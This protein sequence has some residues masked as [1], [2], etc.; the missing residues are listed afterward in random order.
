MNEIVRTNGEALERHQR[1]LGN[2][3]QI[4][5]SF[6]EMGED[7]YWI[8]ERKLYKNLDYETF[9][10]YIA[11]PEVDIKTRTVHQLKQVYRVLV[12]EQKVRPVALL[13]AGYSKASM[14]APYV[15]EEEPEMLIAQA[16]SLS[17]N[18][19]KRWLKQEF[20]PN[21]NKVPVE[22]SETEYYGD[23]WR[24]IHGDMIDVC[25]T[26][27]DASF[28]A[29]VTDPPYPGEFIS[30][31]SSLA[32]QASRLL[33]DG[34]VLLAMSGQNHLPEV[35]RRLTQFEA[36]GLFYRWTISYLLP[37]KEMRAWGRKIWNH[38]KPVIVL[39]KGSPQG[40]WAT[41]VVT[42]P[43]PDK[44]H[45]YWGQSLLGM[46]GLI[47]AFVMPSSRILDP[48]VGG[49]ATID[50]ARALGHECVG[51][52]VDAESIMN[53]RRRLND[54]QEKGQPQHGIRAMAERTIGD[55]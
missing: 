13:E 46:E 5:K 6:L 39:T 42:S 24:L 8:E 30:L 18:D 7:L 48:F 53:T 1:V 45:H 35:Y 4:Q 28:D 15:K 26:M 41:D 17:R 51:I 27:P 32:E 9:N 54:R 49:G 22:L 40:D 21:K 36:D 47:D 19:L 2:R 14:V 50:A 33:V 10:A 25:T 23:G 55:R 20:R 3:L 31:F 16:S 52:D 44:E 29:I 11:S 12:L 38:W 37:G 34:G 43:G